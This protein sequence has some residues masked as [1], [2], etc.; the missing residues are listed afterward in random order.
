MNK[1][2][3]PILTL[4]ALV[5]NAFAIG[6][7]EFIS[8]GLM[9]LIVN[10]FHVT[11]AQAGLTVSLYAIGVTIGAPLLTV[12]T[13]KW[14]RKYLMIVIMLL[15]I[16]G[17]LVAAFALSFSMLL[18]GRI[19]S[20]LA[21]GL[22]MSVSS[23]IAADV[24]EPNKRASAIAIMFTGLTVAT[25]TGVPLG[26]FIGQQTNWHF[27]FIFI[28]IIGALGL[29]AN[30]FLIPKHLPIPGV[31]DLRGIIRIFKNKFLLG[32]FIVT[33]LGYGGTFAA[34][35][36]LTPILED[37]IGYS[38]HAVVLL[39]VVYGI[40]VAI[41]NTIGGHFSNKQ[42]LKSLSLMFGLLSLSLVFLFVAILSNQ[43]ILATLATLVLGLFS[44][45]NVPGL[46]L[47]VVQLA[48][49]YTPKD[50]TLASAFNISA[51]NI[52]I[53]FGSFVG[54]QVTKSIGVTYTPIFGA[55]IVLLAVFLVLQ[56]LHITRKTSSLKEKTAE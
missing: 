20:A 26:T 34:Y 50:I 24:V 29:I 8:V 45:M 41:G 5:I 7:T 25:V 17:N 10:S 42:P 37:K 38:A 12:L 49:E 6:S 52:G 54:A 4:L 9:P 31:V 30:L 21:H 47:Y 44:F 48:E 11:L 14:N 13:G 33:A 27:T 55:I 43:L 15:F 32:S 23:V 46:Q 51:F 56:L 35:T 36:Y 39:L 16:I 19:I 28:A 2:I 3:S 53:A 18:A 22:F 1:R 40:M